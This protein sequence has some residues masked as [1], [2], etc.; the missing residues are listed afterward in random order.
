MGVVHKALELPLGRIVAVKMMQAGEAADPE[1]RERF[2][3]E[4][5]AMARL[6]HPNIVQVYTVGVQDGQPYF[7]MEYVEGGNLAQKIAGKPLPP[8]QAA[9]WLKN[10]ARAMHYAH[11]QKIVH[12]DL[13][14]SNVVLTADHVPKIT[15]FGLAKCLEGTAP[16]TVEGTIMGTPS[17]MA[18]E[19]AA[20][21]VKQTG[22]HSDV[23][24]LGAIL[25]EMLTGRPPFQ[26][27]TPLKTIQL[28]Q[29]QVPVRPWT[30]NSSADAELEAVCLKCLEKEPRQRYGSA[31]ALADDLE[32]WLQG[33]PTLAKPQC[34]LRRSWRFVCSH[35]FASTAVA[36]FGLAAAIISIVSY[37]Q[38]PNRVLE[39]IQSELDK[40]QV[41]NLIGEKGPPRWYQWSTPDDRA[42]VSIA[43]DGT[44]SVHA[45]ECSLLELLPDP[46]CERYRFHVEVRHEQAQLEGRVGIYFGHRK[47]SAAQGATKHSFWGL[48]FNDQLDVEALRPGEPKDL[49]RVKL[50]LYAMKDHWSECLG[51]V[52]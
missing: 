41:V 33:K 23:Y 49:N 14:P 7:S 50:E 52:R 13:K 10:L 17:Y 46:K 42:K 20:G 45:W 24:S 27:E 12:R 34:W 9:E 4:A 18:P 3:R 28:V 2:D 48:G 15:D 22:P 11:Q 6:L 31:E 36:L 8:C 37:L 26:A 5:K 29:T 38:S 43:E 21:R 44:F 51:A 39:R 47:I 30:L 16:A 35:A 19:Q 25:Y 40:G 1:K 32:R